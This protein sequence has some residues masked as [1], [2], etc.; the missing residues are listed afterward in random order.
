MFQTKVK[1]RAYELYLHRVKN[2]LPGNAQT[3]WEEAE[4]EIIMKEIDEEASQIG[5]A[6]EVYY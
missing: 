2:K 3:D 6:E 1:K 5:N 4:R